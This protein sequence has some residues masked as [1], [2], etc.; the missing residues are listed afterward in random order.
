MIWIALAILVGLPTATVLADH[1]I[2]HVEVPGGEIVRFAAEETATVTDVILADP[3]QRL[4]HLPHFDVPEQLVEGHTVFLTVEMVAVPNVSNF[5]VDIV[6]NVSCTTHA[7]TSGPFFPV[8]PFNIPVPNRVHEFHEECEAGGFVFATPDPF[9][10][11]ESGDITSWGPFQANGRT[12][13]FEAPDGQTGEAIEYQF[14]LFET[15]WLGETTVRTMYAWSVPVLEPWTHSDGRERNAY[16][17]IPEDRLLEM[18]IE[19]FRLYHESEM[20][21][22]LLSQ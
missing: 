13:P 22:A 5:T 9:M 6:G 18:G 1:A 11:T 15:D 12:I 7:N 19:S 20:D 16:C 8:G 3:P 10:E 17:P 21:P 14:D 2:G 4:D